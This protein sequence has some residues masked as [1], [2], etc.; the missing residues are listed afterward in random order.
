MSPIVR[1]LLSSALTFSYLIRPSLQS[2]ARNAGSAQNSVGTMQIVMKQWVE[3]L[4]NDR[5][6]HGQK[7]KEMCAMRTVL[8]LITT[9]VFFPLYA[10]K[11]KEPGGAGA[12]ARARQGDSKPRPQQS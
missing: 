1:G 10:E 6:V 8:Q 5:N 4:V 7:P 2:T 3:C 12:V 9:A 11:P